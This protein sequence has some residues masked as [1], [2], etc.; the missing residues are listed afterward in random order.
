MPGSSIPAVLDGLVAVYS[1]AGVPDLDVV[2]GP[3]W[4]SEGS[5]VAVGWNRG[6]GTA[7]TGTEVP[8]DA[9]ISRDFETYAVH[10]LLSVWITDEEL[11]TT[12]RSLFTIF[13]QLDAALAAN[14]TLGGACM[15]AR[16]SEFVLTPVANADGGYL[17]YQYAVTVRAVA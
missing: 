5:F 1:G 9:G 2:Y 4:T 8:A 16:V 10:V 3:S 11:S 15:L 17:D 14:R 6:D 7:V 13:R 12:Y